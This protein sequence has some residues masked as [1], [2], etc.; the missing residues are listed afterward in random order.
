MRV[1]ELLVE[2]K[3]DA[4]MLHAILR[5][6]PPVRQGGSKSA[7]KPKTIQEREAKRATYYIRDR[8]F[9][10][11]PPTERLVPRIHAEKNGQTLGWYW[12]RHEIENYLLEPAIVAESLKCD[13]S[14]YRQAL[15]EIAPTLRDY[16]AARAAIGHVRRSLPPNYDLKTRPENLNEVALP[17]LSYA[18]V[19]NW[20]RAETTTF[21]D[22]A[23]PQLQASVIL[24][25]IERRRNEWSDDVLS[26]VDEILV[27]FAGKDLLAALATT[28]WFTDTKLQNAG[29]M[30]VKLREWIVANPEETLALL[31]EW[32]RFKQMLSGSESD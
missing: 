18:S 4:L 20:A 29:E 16:Q 24:G 2:G 17:D 5:G 19:C 15:L 25:E 23:C 10:F 27:R 31:P 30:C 9:D 13:K 6:R 8:D 21:H 32:Q 28:K 26:S 7:L 3:L 12:C 11:D 22:R 14:S 1:N